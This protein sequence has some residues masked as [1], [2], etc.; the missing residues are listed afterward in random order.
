MPVEGAPRGAETILL[1][2]DEDIV[3][4]LVAEMLEG[5]GYR[6]IAAIGPDEALEVTRA[7]RPLA[8]RRRD[9]VDERARA[10]PRS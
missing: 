4:R 1:V 9:A 3:R 5:Q 10:R 2:E 6:V 7:V 8:H